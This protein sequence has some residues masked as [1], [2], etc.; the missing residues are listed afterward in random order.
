MAHEFMSRG[1]LWNYLVLIWMMYDAKQMTDRAEAISES[2]A[3][4]GS[5]NGDFTC[6]VF[7]HVHSQ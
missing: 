7:L 4:A 2:S 3:N 1:V 6:G 5:E